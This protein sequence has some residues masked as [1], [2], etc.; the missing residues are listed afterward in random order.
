M[1]QP[2]HGNTSS[3]I[4]R[5]HQI[6]TAPGKPLK[7]DGATFN[8]Q[9]MS[10]GRDSFNTEGVTGAKPLPP[11]VLAAYRKPMKHPAPLGLPCASLQ[12]R[13]YHVRNLEFFADFCLRAAF[14]LG[15]PARGPNPLPRRTERWTLL[16][17]NF[18]NKKAQE[19]FERVTHKRLVTILDGEKSVIETWLAFIRRWQFYGVGM[20]ANVWAWESLEVGKNMDKAYEEEIEKQLEEK[21]KL[22][23]FSERSKRSLEKMIERQGPRQVAVPMT[24]LR[25]KSMTK[26]ERSLLEVDGP[27][28]LYKAPRENQKLVS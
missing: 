11:N 15:L 18:V 12:L 20:K 26:E 8:G 27:D 22:F 5:S 3:P 2:D 10:K 23:G 24:N 17:S 14:Y 4:S 9:Q 1:A 19:N 13:S 6:G 21:M 28:M 7:E 16:K 25:D